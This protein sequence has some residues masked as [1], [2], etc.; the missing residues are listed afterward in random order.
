MAFFD[1][2][3]GARSDGV[4]MDEIGFGR[5]EY[6]HP[7]K[8]TWNQKME[9][10]KMMFMSFSIVIFGFQPFIFTFFR[11]VEMYNDS[12]FC[13]QNACFVLRWWD[14]FIKSLDFFFL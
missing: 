5:A 8:S 4:V 1:L 6:L 2:A 7:G 3:S 11:G 12:D 10:G 9:I 13:Y 14:E